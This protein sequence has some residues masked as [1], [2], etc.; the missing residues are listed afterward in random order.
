MLGIAAVP[1]VQSPWPS[2]GIKG[3]VGDVPVD[4]AAHH[5]SRLSIDYLEARSSGT[6]R[7]IHMAGEG[8]QRLVVVAIEIEELESRHI[9]THFAGFTAM[10]GRRD[11]PLQ[12]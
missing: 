11:F 8:I 7:G 6:E 2:N 5:E 4:L 1:R 3:W 10:T 9:F 12:P